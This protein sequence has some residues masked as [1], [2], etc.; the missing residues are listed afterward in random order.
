MIDVPVADEDA[1]DVAE[2]KTDRAEAAKQRVAPFL[3]PDPG[4]EES[5]AAALLLDRVHV[6]GPARLGEWDRNRD[7][8]NPQ[9]GERGRHPL[10]FFTSSVSS[11][12]AL[13]RS[14]TSP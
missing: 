10:S 6:G 11:G 1:A 5:D 3:R 4:V 8:V 7:P 2:R 9:P 12:S 13:K 14:P